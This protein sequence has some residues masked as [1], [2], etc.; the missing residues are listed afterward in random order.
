MLFLDSRLS[1]M[2]VVSRCCT[3]IE[4]TDLLLPDCVS[5]LAALL[6][7]PESK[8]VQRALQCLTS[9]ASRFIK[10]QAD[11]APL[12]AHGM[13]DALVRLL[14]SSAV[15]EDGCASLDPSRARARVCVRARA[16]ACVCTPFCA[17]QVSQ[18]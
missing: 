3:H 4:P 13:G 7:Q 11:T 2:V 12:A 10:E 18:Y 5:S 1:A 8:I 9:L 15:R 6:V 17:L 16:C 14:R